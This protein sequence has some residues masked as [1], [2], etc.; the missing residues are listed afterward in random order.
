MPRDDN[1]VYTPPYGDVEPGTTISDV[2]ANGTI[3]DIAAA[4]TDSLSRTGQGGMQYPLTFGDGTVSA[5]G[6]A[7]TNETGSGLYR[8][9]AAD[10]RLTLQ[11]YGDT[12]RWY[13]GIA[14]V[15]NAADT[16]WAA[17]VYQGGVGS[18][19]IGTTNLDT[20]VWSTASSAWIRQAK[21]AGGSLP[22]GSSTLT[23]LQWNNGSLVWEAVAPTT[24]SNINDGSVANTIPTWVTGTS[25]WTQN[26]KLTVNPSTGA[27]A[28]AGALTVSGSLTAVGAIGYGVGAGGTVTQLTSKSTAV[29]LNKLCGTIIMNNAALASGYGSRVEFIFNNS[30]IEQHDT[31]VYTTTYGVYT[32][33]GSYAGTGVHWVN[34]VNQD[35]FTRSD[36]LEINFVVIKSS[37]T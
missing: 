32:A 18:V 16:A 13:Q 6:I 20:L 12:A 33:T 1:G 27:A 7:W 25:K 3:D 30:M 31:V 24:S 28:L 4:L 29:T 17:V 23:A 26:T 37:V 19:P 10:T 14:Y 36:P 5:P 8:A 22:V 9:G 34:V 11:G 35:S 2:W 15:R 21:N